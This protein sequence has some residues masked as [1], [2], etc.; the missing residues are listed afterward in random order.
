M[1]GWLLEFMST[2][3]YLGVALLITVENIFPPIPSELILTF[4]G[5]MTT[6]T[7]M[8]VVG[9]VI[10]A[11]VGSVFGAIILYFVGSKITQEKL[12]SLLDG[13]LGKMLHF[14]REDV[15][16]A[17]QWFNDRGNYT[18][19][20][21]RCIPIVRSL[22]SIPAGIARMNL[23]RFFTL[24]TIGSLIW[25]IVLIGLGAVAGASWQ[26]VAKYASDYSLSA[27]I[28]GI[29]FL[30]IGVLYWFKKRGKDTPKNISDN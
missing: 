16:T 20:F 19:L 4:A 13:K 9:T 26:Q 30:I 14:K 23:I 10:S 25:N 21:C 5:F 11:T 12:E 17:M 2:F 22:I 18:V 6:Y 7:K 15:G 3:G 24:T 29:V 8:N 28:V 1:N 27:K